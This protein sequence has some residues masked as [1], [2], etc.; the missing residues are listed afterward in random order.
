[1]HGAV[2]TAAIRVGRSQFSVKKVLEHKPDRAL[3]FGYVVIDRMFEAVVTQIA[4]AIVYGA[5]IVVP[6]TGKI[7]IPGI[8]DNRYE[9]MAQSLQ[10]GQALKE[11]H[12]HAR[13]QP[14]GNVRAE[15]EGGIPFRTG[16]LRAYDTGAVETLQEIVADNV[17]V[18]GESRVDVEVTEKRR[19]HAKRKL[20]PH[21]VAIVVGEIVV[22]QGALQGYRLRKERLAPFRKLL[23]IADLHSGVGEVFR[24][25]DAVVRREQSPQRRAGS[26]RKP[27]APVVE[28]PQTARTEWIVPVLVEPD[29]HKHAP[30]AA[31]QVVG[32]L[33]A[34]R[35]DTVL[36]VEGLAVGGVGVGLLVDD[37]LRIDGV[38]VVVAIPALKP[39]VH[40]EG[41]RGT[42]I[43]VMQEAQVPAVVFLVVGV[44]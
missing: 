7:R 32:H 20:K 10:T 26:D 22:E 3:A 5:V 6:R 43:L 39:Q 33:E 35:C 36:V 9:R 41:S 17:M 37:G 16:T 28:S 14:G 34:G 38:Q 13:V 31:S 18:E 27:V 21:P 23:V 25:I 40:V 11:R 12:L 44:P 15:I 30:V 4:G 24:R 8:G 2:R 42:E 19:L 29:T 1:M